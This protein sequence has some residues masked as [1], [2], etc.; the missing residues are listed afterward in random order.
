[1]TNY[2]DNTQQIDVACKALELIKKYGAQQARVSLNIGS[3]S[4]FAYLDNELDKLQNSNDRSLYLQIFVDGRYGA[5]ST[6][7]LEIKELELFIKEIISITKLLS[8]DQYRSL[9]PTH[10]YYKGKDKDLGQFDPYILNMDPLLKKE[11]AYNTQSEIYSKNKKILSVSSEFS[12]YLDYQYMIDT[13]GFEGDSLQSNFTISAE[14]SVKGRGN[15][16]PEGWWYESA[17]IYNTLVKENIGKIALERALGKL[18]AKKVKSAK[19]NMIVDRSCSSRL[20]SPIFSA[21]NGGNIQQKNSFLID[22]LGEKVFPNI[23]TITDTP[24]EFGMQGARYFDGEGIATKE[25]NIIENGIVNTY[26]INTYNANK[27]NC[28]ATIES[29]S[30]PNITSNNIPME[31][32]NFSATDMI[33]ILEKGIYVTG[34]NGGNC[35]IGT[36]DFSYGI[37]GFYFEGGQIL[38]PIKELNISGNIVSLWN[39]LA[40]AGNDARKCAR[41]QIPSLSF[42]NVNFTGV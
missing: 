40:F 3:Q 30:V 29:I 23:L 16:R 14:C 10:L 7:R 22:K 13:N 12:E 36:G 42:F 26:F 6:N 9:P 25:R 21:L 17:M 20:I 31:Y 33:T 27:L 34:F 37:E 41:W 18:G 28:P 19:M 11:I 24:L 38:F 4:S 15:S 1:M 2:I 35:N 5:Y 32:S 8:Q 39:E